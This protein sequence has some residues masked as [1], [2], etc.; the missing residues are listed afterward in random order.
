M[1]FVTSKVMMSTSACSQR[2]WKT[3][4]DVASAA[5]MSNDLTAADVF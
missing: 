2:N 1:R 5:T 3:F 4:A